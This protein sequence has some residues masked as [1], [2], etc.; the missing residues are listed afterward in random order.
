MPEAGFSFVLI[1]LA[2]AVAGVFWLRK[3]AQRRQDETGEQFPTMWASVG[4]LVGIPLVVSAVLGFP[5]TWEF[6]ELGRFR[7]VGGLEIQIELFSALMA[8]TVYTSSFIAEIVRAG[9]LAISRGQTEAAHS[10]GLRPQPTL[11]LVIVPQALRVIVPPLTSQY[12]NLT[13]NSSLGIAIGYADL[14][15][16]FGGISLNQTGP[17]DRDHR[18]VHAGLPSLQPPHLVVHELVQQEDRAGGAMTG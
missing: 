16:V 7:F 3:W 5:M 6:A 10:L 15:N 9:I 11:R 17:G 18:H 1:A 2:V 8:L 13:K 12:L 14:L 4:L